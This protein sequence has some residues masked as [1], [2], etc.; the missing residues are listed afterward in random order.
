MP[1][2]LKLLY[3]LI[4]IIG[5]HFFYPFSISDQ[6]WRIVLYQLMYV[7]LFL[8]AVLVV[9]ETRRYKIIMIVVAALWTILGP[10]TVFYP[11]R[12][13]FS[14]T[15]YG[16]VFIFQGMLAYALLHYIF[17]TKIVDGN[18]LIAASIVYLLLG[19]IF[20]PIFG[21]IEILTWLPD[22]TTHAF[23]DGSYS[24]EESVFPWQTI[25]YFSFV[26]LTTLGFGDVLPVSHWARSVATFEAVVGVLYVTIIVARLVGLYSAEEAVDEMKIEEN[27]RNAA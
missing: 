20:I 23:I 26:N 4:L 14:I 3:L 12:A 22:Q 27:E 19:A 17:S 7:S 5:V 9:A 21:I 2:N 15:S 10:L 18:I 1:K 11:N 24:Y 25:I 6:A 13:F 16:L 8:V